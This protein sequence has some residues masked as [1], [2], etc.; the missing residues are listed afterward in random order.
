MYREFAAI[1]AISEATRSAL[2]AHIGENA[3]TIRVVPNG[4]DGG[5]FEFSGKRRS[6]PATDGLVILCIGSL[7]R[8]KDQATIIRAIAKI[9]G[10]RLLLAGDGPLRLELEALALRLGVGSRVDFLG[11]REDIPQLVANADLYVQSSIWEGFCLAV[12]EAMCGRVPCI[13]SCN[14]GL[15]EVVGDAGIYFQPGNDDQLASAIRALSRN[16]EERAAIINRG[17]VQAARFTLR[18][19]GEAY[20]RLYGDTIRL[21]S[22]TDGRRI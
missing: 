12:V 10:A 17:V 9:D 4:V 14:S 21:L 6:E 20:E 1:A 18:A 11:V 13:V 15:Q 19:C 2:T 16:A 22:N 5:R 3:P 7:T 8:V